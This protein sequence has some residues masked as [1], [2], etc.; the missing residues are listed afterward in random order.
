MVG[1]PRRRV[2]QLGGTTLVLGLSGCLDAVS[3]DDDDPN[4]DPND[5]S[6]PD[7][8]DPNGG[9]TAPEGRVVN[10]TDME[11]TF[12][13][14]ILEDGRAV[15]INDIDVG[16]GSTHSITGNIGT[17][18]NTYLVDVV[19]GDAWVEQ[20]VEYTLDEGDGQTAGVL[21]ITLTES[22]ELQIEFIPRE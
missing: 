18:G 1:V 10:Q 6:T 5:D 9:D 12:E 2:M 21:E 14:S 13:I 3:G 11:H 22:D 19:A 8:D 20:D 7:D 17:M 15:Y 4:D 16:P